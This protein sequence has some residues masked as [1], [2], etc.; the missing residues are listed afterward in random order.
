MRPI[1]DTKKLKKVVNLA[2]QSETVVTHEITD[3]KAFKEWLVNLVSTR[4]N[5]KSIVAEKLFDANGLPRMKKALTHWSMGEA[6]D[7]E[8]LETIGDKTVNKCFM[9]YLYRRFPELRNDERGNF[10]LTEAFRQLV[11]K[12]TLSKYCEEIGLNKFIRYKEYVYLDSNGVRRKIEEDESLREDV[13]EAFCGALED[14]VDNRIEFTV[15]YST[16]YAL[17]SSFLD[18]Q[19]ISIDLDELVSSVTKLKEIFDVE[20]KQGRANKHEYKTFFNT[21]IIPPTYNVSLFLTF[22]DT[23]LPSG[24]T[25][26]PEKKFTVSNIS[27]KEEGQDQLALQAL[28]WLKKNLKMEWKK[29]N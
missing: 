22:E 12:G 7:Y 5:I 13:F 14:L 3:D 26:P 1:T 8:Q 16:V 29:P 11:K 27:R 10:K 21:D 24:R 4:A 15:G 23:N 9:W 19:E 18:T 20:K 17:M 2:E 25:A 28:E 6:L